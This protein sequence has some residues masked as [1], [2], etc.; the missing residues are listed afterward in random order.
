MRRA[1]GARKKD[2]AAQ[3]LVE[4][5]APHRRGRFAGG[6]ARDRGAFAIHRFAGWPT[7]VAPVLLLLAMVMALLVGVGFGFYPACHAS[8]LE[9]MEALRRE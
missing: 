5:V 6:G 3:F 7:A 8:R 1:L 9:P 2:I 4:S